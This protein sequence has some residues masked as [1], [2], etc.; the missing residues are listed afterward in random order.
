MSDYIGNRISSRIPNKLRVKIKGKKLK[1]KQY[2]TLDISSGGIFIPSTVAPPLG[3]DVEVRLYLPRTK[4]PLFIQGK[5]LRI[6][7]EGNFKHV[8]GFAVEFKKMD[9]E[10]EDKYLSFMN[11]LSQDEL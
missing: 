4:K 8:E 6:K 10:T 5:I 1:E 7:W 11:K 2:Y 3:L 9:R